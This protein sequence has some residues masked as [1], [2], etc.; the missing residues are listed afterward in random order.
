M[1]TDVYV[2]AQ[3]KLSKD[4]LK[5]VNMYNNLVDS[6]YEPPDKLKKDLHELIGDDDILCGESIEVREGDVFEV[7]IDGKDDAMYD[8]GM[9]INMAD[10]P[11]GTTSIRIYT[12]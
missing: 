4:D 1:L 10:I 6:G 3:R 7:G 5:K 8:D 11:E 12:R 9:I 2:V